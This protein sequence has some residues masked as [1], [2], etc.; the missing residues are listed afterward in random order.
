M[1]KAVKTF[2][3]KHWQWLAGLI[4]GVVLT[5]IAY[6]YTVGGF[7][8]RTEMRLSSVEDRVMA[9]DQKLD[10][11]LE[12]SANTTYQPRRVAMQE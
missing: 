2:L 7:V 6:A 11:V 9:V 3:E 8:V 5:I 10:R 4:F 12:N 1:A